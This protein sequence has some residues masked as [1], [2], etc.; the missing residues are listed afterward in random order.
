METKENNKENKENGTQDV[1]KVAD[2]LADKLAEQPVQQPVKELTQ[3]EK[4]TTKK[5]TKK[6]KKKTAKPVEQPVK[7][8]TLADKIWNALKDQPLDIFALSGQKLS[9]YAQRADVLPDQLFLIIKAGAAVL[10]LEQMLANN[11]GKLG[12]LGQYEKFVIE[13]DTRFVKIKIESIY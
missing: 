11:G 5:T 13:Q 3:A 4:K 9:D 1:K 7:E 6:T 10:A 8:L 2:Q 12:L